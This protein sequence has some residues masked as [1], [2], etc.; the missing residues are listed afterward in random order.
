LKLLITGGLGHIGSSLIRKISLKI[1]NAKITLLDN[2]SSERYCSI[3]NLPIKK[4]IKLINENI[5]KN[6]LKKIIPKVDVIIHLAAMTDAASSF[7]K[8]E[9]IMKN[10]FSNTKIVADI[11][12][13]NNKKL[14]F[15][16]STSVYGSGDKIMYEN[17]LKNLNPQSPYAV[18]KIKEENYINKIKKQKKLKASILR[19]GTIVGYS[20]GMRFHTAVNKFC[21]QA[22]LSQKIDV[23]KTAR[24]QKRPYLGINDAVNSIIFFAKN[25]KKY[26]ET[27]NVVTE[28]LTVNQILT[29]I[30][31]NRST[32]VN[33]MT[34]KI[35]N[36]LSYEVSTKKIDSIKVK[37]KDS[38][39]KLIGEELKILKKV[40]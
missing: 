3:F 28:N 39:E 8:E 33:L 9:I 18:T 29:H 17:D 25:K 10:N 35:M 26:N 31:K 1:P 14:I 32:K 4:R 11:C 12:S 13:K 23:W 7:G 34:H 5:D 27:Y 37:M 36:Q 19:F 15:I 20:P 30:S 21:L 6:N 2:F 40:Y 38:I 22:S 16:S 24:H